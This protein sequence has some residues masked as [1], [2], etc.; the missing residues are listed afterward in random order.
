MVAVWSCLAKQKCQCLL[1]LS[2]FLFYFEV[3]SSCLISSLC[4]SLCQFVMCL[5]VPSSCSW[6]ISSSRFLT[7][8]FGFVLCLLLFSAFVDTFLDSEFIALWL[9]VDKKD[10]LFVSCL[11]LCLRRG[12]LC[13][14]VMV[15]EDLGMTPNKIFLQNCSPHVKIT[16][17][18]IKKSMLTFGFSKDTDNSLLRESSVF[19]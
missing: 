6:V 17:G 15:F 2:Y 18:G 16:N 13:L 9:Y 8:Y 3:L 11:P 14:T 10:H 7:H 5:P 4:L 1:G 19:V 12:P